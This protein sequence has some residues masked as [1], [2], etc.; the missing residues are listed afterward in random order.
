MRGFLK[1]V[2]A[3]FIALVLFTVIGIFVLIGIATSAASSDKPIIGSKA[4]LVLD[5][6]VAFKE[7]YQ[8][9][10]FATLLN[11]GEETAPSLFQVTQLLK[12]AKQD[13]AVKGL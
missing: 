4:V 7:Q 1:I 5:L 3:T 2:F 8:E 11:E 12:H 6:G 9:D 10:P 13:S